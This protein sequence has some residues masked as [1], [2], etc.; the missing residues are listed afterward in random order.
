M[1]IAWRS[2]RERTL[3]PPTTSSSQL[4]PRY[5]MVTSGEVRS[6]IPFDAI[7][8]VRPTSPPTATRTAWSKVSLGIAEES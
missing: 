7:S 4:T 1:A 5:R 3:S 2:L 8:A 6:L